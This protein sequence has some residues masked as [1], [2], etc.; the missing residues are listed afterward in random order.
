VEYQLKIKNERIKLVLL[1]ILETKEQH[2][3][4]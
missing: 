4:K 2:L 3:I 1:Q